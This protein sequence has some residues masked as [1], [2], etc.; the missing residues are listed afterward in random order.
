[1]NRLYQ[2]QLNNSQSSS[3]PLNEAAELNKTVRNS[4]NPNMVMNK[5]IQSNPRLKQVYDMVQQ[6]GGNGKQIFFQ[7]AQQ[8][9]IDPNTILSKLQ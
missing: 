7:L 3:A 9:G 2:Q 5:L 8:K 6:N 4:N 1:M